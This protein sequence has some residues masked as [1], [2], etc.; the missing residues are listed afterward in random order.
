[1]HKIPTGTWVVVADGTHARLFHNVGMQDALQLKQDDLVKPDSVD[2]QGQLVFEQYWSSMYAG[3]VSGGNQ[4]REL[5][6]HSF[7]ED[8]RGRLV[9]EN[10]PK[11]EDG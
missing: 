3:E 5:A 6:D 2:E 8:A 11:K 4:G 9:G 7:P 10:A 1:M